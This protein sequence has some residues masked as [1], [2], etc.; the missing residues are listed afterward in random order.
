MANFKLSLL[1]FS[2]TLFYMNVNAQSEN[3]NITIKSVGS[4]K[5]ME[6]AK[7]NALRSALEQVSGTYLSSNTLVINDKLVS[8]NISSITA[9]TIN[10]YEI[11]NQYASREL[12]YVTINTEI[13]PTKFAEFVS[14]KTGAQMTSKN[15]NKA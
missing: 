14:M 4:G 10:K 12:F 6:D 5:T 3:K 15:I 11:I 2:L 7:N 9:G 13:S 1:F 8:D